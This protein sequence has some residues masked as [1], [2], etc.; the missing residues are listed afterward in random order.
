MISRWASKREPAMQ[1]WSSQEYLAI[2]TDYHGA[3][4][5]LSTMR[6][7]KKWYLI[8]GYVELFPRDMP[9]PESFTASDR[10]WTVPDSGGEVT[11]A[12]SALAMP[13]ADALAWYEEAAQGRVTIPLK[14]TSLEIASPPFGAEPILGRF[15]V[16]EDVPFAAQ[17]HGGPRIHRLVPME[18]PAEAVQKLGSNV[19]A[20]EWLADSVGIDPF[21]FEEWLG[22]ISLLA[23]DPLLS[24][25]GHFVQGRREDGS[26]RVVI[27]AHRRRYEGYP[28]GEADALKLVLLQRRPGGWTD[29]LPTSFDDDGFAIADYPEPVS[30]QGYAISCPTRGLLRMVPPTLWMGQIRV[31]FG[32]VNTVLDVEVPT[33]GRR[34]PASRYRTNRV[35][36][37]GKVHV[38]EA[39]PRSG[40]IRVVELQEARKRRRR[41]ESA[42][43][44]LF[45]AFE[46]K[47]GELTAEDLALMR[48]EAEAYVAGLVAGAHRRVI[49]VDPDFGLRELQNYALR[50]M[51]YGVGVKILTGAPRMRDVSR[52]GDPISDAPEDSKDTASHATH[53]EYL[54]KQ[55]RHV[56]SELGDGAPE[57]F[58]M[59]GFSKPLFHDRFVVV[60]D[61]VWASGPSFNEL[62]ERIGL[63]SRVHEPQS[64]IAAIEQ[65]LRRSQLLSDWIAKAGL[66]DQQAE[67]PDASEI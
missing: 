5:R 24:G 42:P 18:E 9:Y 38:G 11:L 57:V 53:G 29:V 52:S 34:K 7:E 45:G 46:G 40:A 67:G 63:I 8:F 20:R 50:V 35:T 22:S 44:R 36:D 61:V 51:R 39:L 19:C 26:E 30:E 66:Q 17:W 47:K 2:A 3:L 37:T 14:E 32:I 10:P 16:G 12:L 64:V 55:L 62:G 1:V 49:F 13:V 4:V 58:V 15:S 56:R 54:L 27:Q 6:A 33:G 21:Q 43:Q 23:P 48:A 25:V 60:D 31:D 65:A 59:P 28:D 41:I